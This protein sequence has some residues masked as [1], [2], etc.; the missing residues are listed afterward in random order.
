MLPAGLDAVLI[1]DVYAEVG[2]PIS[3]LTDVASALKP[4]GRVGIVDL[5]LIHI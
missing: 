1:V 4:Q 2:D 3:L 5:S